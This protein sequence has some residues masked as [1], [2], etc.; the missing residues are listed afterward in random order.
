MSHSDVIIITVALFLTST[1]G[2]YATIRCINQHIKTPINSLTRRG[3][4]ELKYIETSTNNT[5]DLLQPQQI[6]T[7][8]INSGLEDSMNLQRTQS[9]WSGNPP[10]YNTLDLLQPQQ[11]YTYER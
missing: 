8:N 6:Y 3:D 9:Y 11:V 2:V 10:S 7:S 4:I 1:V 5:L